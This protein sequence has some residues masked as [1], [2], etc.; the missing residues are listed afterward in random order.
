MHR[1]F[2]R[3]LDHHENDNSD[4]DFYIAEAQFE[5]L[6]KKAKEGAPISREAVYEMA[7]FPFLGVPM[8]A[9]MVPV[10]V[11][12]FEET[13]DIVDTDELLDRLGPKGTVDAFI[14]A[15]DSFERQ[16]AIDPQVF[17]ASI[18]IRSDKASVCI[19]DLVGATIKT[20]TFL[21]ED[22]LTV[23]LLLFL[24][25]LKPNWQNGGFLSDNGT[26]LSPMDCLKDHSRVSICEVKHV[27]QPMTKKEWLDL[28]E[29]PGEES[30]DPDEYFGFEEDLE[31]EPLDHKCEE[32]HLFHDELGSEDSDRGNAPQKGAETLAKRRKTEC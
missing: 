12:A 7:G 26:K 9:M 27:A 31:E 21:A 13:L 14:K 15:R 30:V 8:N 23:L 4:M 25:E 19:T 10:D 6:K 29:M 20:A 24:N 17:T 28:V 18:T 11:G 1:A 16:A 3:T 5:Q 22:R 32:P 2:W